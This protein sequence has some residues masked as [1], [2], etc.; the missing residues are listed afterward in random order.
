MPLRILSIPTTIRRFLVSSSL[1]EVT[2]QIHS[3]RASGVK[4]GHSFFAVASAA[5]AFRR[6]AGSGWTVPPGN[7]AALMFGIDQG[8]LP[9]TTNGARDQRSI[10]IVTSIWGLE[11]RFIT[12]TSMSYT[13]SFFKRSRSM[14]RLISFT[15]R[16]GL[17]RISSSRR[18]QLA[19]VR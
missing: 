11:S 13:R 8:A 1:A 10:L 7:F 18:A 4:S 6:S 15:L 17:L 2:Q 14:S 19:S 16:F 12:T 5:M 3:L 9:A